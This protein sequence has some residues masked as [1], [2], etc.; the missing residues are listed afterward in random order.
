MNKKKE[1]DFW[2]YSPFLA[3]AIMFILWGMYMIINENYGSSIDSWSLQYT[4]TGGELL[5]LLG[6]IFLIVAYYSLSPFSK[7][8]EFFEKPVKRNRNKK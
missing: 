5:I 8:R 6:V 4:A 1:S 2:N 7:V 3:L